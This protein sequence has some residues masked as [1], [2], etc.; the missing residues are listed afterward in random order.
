MSED[1]AFVDKL[2]IFERRADMPA[3]TLLYKP[4]DLMDEDGNHW[5]NNVTNGYISHSVSC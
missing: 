2:P 3:G 4:F 5:F 1:D